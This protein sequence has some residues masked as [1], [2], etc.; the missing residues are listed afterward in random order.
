LVEITGKPLDELL[1]PGQ[2]RLWEIP[3]CGQYTRV[4]GNQYLA[5]EFDPKLDELL[6]DPLVSLCHH[7]EDKAWC[8]GCGHQEKQS[9]VELTK[10]ENPKRPKVKA[11][12]RGPREQ[13]RL[14]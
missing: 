5:I 7:D 3:T 10:S 9:A 12:K 8:G 1:I 13:L 4:G 2:Q 11:R 6:E 14:F